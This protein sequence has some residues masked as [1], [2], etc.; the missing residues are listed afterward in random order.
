[1]LTQLFH[2]DFKR[3]EWVLEKINL[4]SYELRE[5]YP[6]KRIS[7]YDKHINEVRELTERMRAE[8]L[9]RV[10]EEF[11]AQKALFYRQKKLVL[12]EIRSEI[13][14]LGFKNIKFPNIG[15]HK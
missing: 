3:Y 15:D 13:T 1:M 2:K 12:A 6:Y 10:R 14:E 9:N 11:E 4:Q 5:P 7:R 8:K